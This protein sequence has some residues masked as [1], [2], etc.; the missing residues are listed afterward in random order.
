RHAAA[1]K[2]APKRKA[3]YA[4]EVAGKRHLEAAG[5]T[6]GDYSKDELNAGCL[7]IVGPGGGKALAA[8]AA[9]VQKWLAGG[10]ILLVIGLDGADLNAFLPNKI[11][12]AKADHIAAYF[13]PPAKDSLLAGVGPADVE[14]RDP[15]QLSLISAGATVLGDGVLAKADGINLV[16]CQLAPWQ[17]DP[18][19]AMNLKRTFRHSAFVVSR[20]ASNMG[21]SASTPILARFHTPVDKSKVEKRWLEG[22]YLDTPEEWDDP[23]RYFRW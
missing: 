21:A 2:P 8:D 20:L 3:H 23:Y 22:L 4:G 12:T 11:S 5:L 16:W 13:D 6:L 10:G 14:N 9:A 18:T 1:W 7:L 17:F 19:K 15:R